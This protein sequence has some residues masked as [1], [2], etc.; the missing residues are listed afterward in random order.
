MLGEGYVNRFNLEGRSY[1]VIPQVERDFRLTSDA[2]MDYYLPTAAG[3]QVP[4]SA[5]VKLER[6]VEPSQRTQ[7]QQLN[8]VTV[9][10]TMAPGFPLVRDST[11][12]M[13]RQL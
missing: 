13:S 12:W 6:S 4:L 10:G 1:K 3:G 9:Q 5:L 11:I 7:F 8:A 2:L